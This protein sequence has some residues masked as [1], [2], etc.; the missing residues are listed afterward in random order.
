MREY[1]LESGQ[2]IHNEN[3][4]KE[5]LQGTYK[6]NGETKTITNDANFPF[7][8]DPVILVQMYEVS[9]DGKSAQFIV[10]TGEP[11]QTSAPW[12]DTAPFSINEGES[13]FYEPENSEV[14]HLA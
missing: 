3:L 6:I 14:G 7:S 13:Y 10:R 4:Q 12:K 11:G 1:Y 2:T 5:N 8:E 9:K